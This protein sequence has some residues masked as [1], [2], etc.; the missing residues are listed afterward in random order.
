MPKLF[1]ILIWVAVSVLGVVAVGVMAF[2]RGEPVNAL[3]LVIAGVCTFAV[4]YRFYSAW[5]MAKVLTIDD[6]RAPAAITCN[7]GKDFVPT[8]KWVVFGHHFAAIAG[9]GPLV[10]PV[11]AAQFGYLPGALWILVGATLGGGVHDSVVLF[12]SMRRN[13]KSLGQMIREELNPVLGII[14]LIS[15]LVIMTILLAVLGLVVVK[16]LAES[17]WGLFTIAAT[18]PLAFIMGLAI[19]SGK[20]SVTH[21]TLFGVIGLLAAVVAGKYLPP[22]WAAALTLKSTQLAW[23]IMIYGFAA[24]VLPVWMLL[25]PRDYLSTFMKLGTVAL[26]GL[27]IVFLAPPL[28][29]PALTPFIHGGGFVVPGPVFPFVCITI[30]CGAISGFH[31][32]IASGTTPK[33]LTREKDIRLVGYGAMVVEML[34]ALMAVIA[35]CALPPGEYFAINSPVDP[36]NSAAVAAQIQ[37]INSYGPA[38]AISQERMQALASDLGEIHMIGKVGG[39]P[40]FAVGMA[41]MFAAIIPGK[42]ALSLWYHFAIM[43]EAL[44]ILTTLD[45][46]TRVGR[47]ILQDLLG[48]ISPR[49]RDTRSWPANILA[50]GLLVAAWGF[51]LYQGALDPEGIAKSLW[52]LFGISNQLLAVIAFCFGTVVLIKMGK[53]RYC[54]ITLAPMLLLTVAT[55]SAG[56]M[57]IFSANAAGFLPAIRKLEGKIAGGLDAPALAAARNSLFNA[58]IDVMVTATLLVFVTLIVLGTAYECWLLLTKRKPIVLRESPYEL[59]REPHAAPEDIAPP[60]A[61]A[62][63]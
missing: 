51:F 36:N 16:A 43:F 8:P 29:M 19:K 62:I 63:M 28:Q 56:L 23:A 14:A 46:G 4:A 39:A 58:R 44:F 54:W 53:A 26:L 2:Q 25:A 15:L 37:T 30:A 31:S 1:R 5:L 57:K 7:D 9:P 11:L 41:R 52:P 55:F 24:S 34:V 20:V 32:L 49:L 13:G 22:A 12:S 61:P 50:T 45:A 27:F 18:I 47:F 60:I 10:G 42:T 6:R 33:M 48:E 40:T 17:P 21:A 35:A 3:W 59:L 38:Y